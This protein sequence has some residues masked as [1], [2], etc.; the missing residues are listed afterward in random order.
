MWFWGSP[1]WQTK[2]FSEILNLPQLLAEVPA[3]KKL[4]HS[5]LE[6]L[7]DLIAAFAK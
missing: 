1:I 2:E 6:I 3:F 7:K 4:K 5:G